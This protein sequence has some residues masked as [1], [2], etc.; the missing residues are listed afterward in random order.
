MKKR[1]ESLLQKAMKHNK[2][3]DQKKSVHIT[4]KKKSTGRVVKRM[5]SPY[6]IRGHLLI[7]YD[8]K[9]KALRSYHTERIT[10]MK[11][12]AF[13]QGFEKKANRAAEL[14]GLGIL[15]APSFQRLRGKPMSEDNEAKAEVLGLGVLAA[16]T[17][18]HWGK[19]LLGS[20]G[21]KDFGKRLIS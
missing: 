20:T 4:Y 17:T 21:V 15:A 13:W 16:P 11:T 1:H 12:A 3:N 19:N 6:E 10:H 14:A 2:N 9:R 18:Y 8:H 7:G 5:V